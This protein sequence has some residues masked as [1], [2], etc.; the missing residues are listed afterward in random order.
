MNP[1]D[2]DFA[3]ALPEYN[4]RAA[5]CFVPVDR[6]LYH[7]GLY[8]NRCPDPYRKDPR[9][10]LG[11]FGLVDWAVVWA[12]F[13]DSTVLVRIEFPASF[14]SCYLDFDHLRLVGVPR[15]VGN[16]YKHPDWMYR[17]IDTPPEFCIRPDP[18]VGALSSRRDS[19]FPARAGTILHR[20]DPGRPAEYYLPLPD[21]RAASLGGNIL[22]S[23]LLCP[24]AALM[25][26]S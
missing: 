4:F 1:T 12:D 21:R 14:L 3:P 23:C 17:T 13:V 20:R 7:R 10:H 5:S 25:Y 26:R 15:S 11:H 18:I 24:A 19:Y 6:I 9:F 2:F 16:F 22:Q 8:P